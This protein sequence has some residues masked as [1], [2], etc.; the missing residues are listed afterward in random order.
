MEE[1]LKDSIPPHNLEAEMATLGALLIDWSSIGDI[2]T[3]LR[4]EHFYS[5]QNQIIYN[6]L[7][8]LFGTG[9]S[10]DVLTLET[11]LTK[12][13]EL[14]KAGG[15]AYI[16]SLTDEVPSAA[17]IDYYAHVV[18]DRATRRSLIKISSEIKTTA[19]DESR[20]SRAILDEAE[21][22]IFALADMGQTIQIHDMHEVVDKTTK[23]IQ[24]QYHNHDS[25]SGIP[26]GFT[27]LDSMTSGFQKSELSIIGARPSMGKTAMAL[28]MM[29]NI[30]VNNKIPC[31]F[32]SLEMSFEQIGQR[33]LSQVARI[34]GHKIRSGMMK[35]DDLQKINDAAGR[36]FDA[37]IYIVDTPNMQLLDLRAMAR[38]MVQSRQVQ[39][40]FIDYIGLISTQNP[41]AP[42]YEQVSEI[43]KSLKSLARELNIPVVALCQVARD[44]EG[45][46]PTL[47]QL[48]GSGSIEQD[49]D[50]VMFIHRERKKTEGGEMEPVQ[51][52]KLIVAKQRNGPIGDVNLLFLSSYTKFENKAN[53][54]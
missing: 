45:N 13:N 33:L 10:G 30:A 16:A 40:I 28:S 51:D 25:Y 1:R 2:V 26:C 31:G 11:E 54:D 46:E 20:E 50:V 5:Q 34:P 37:P 32:F 29:E 39:I 21:K 47:A 52:A 24:Q 17:N 18:L 38:R 53:E 6:A 9:I 36:V 35:L 41:S 15:P 22:K 44:A 12:S 4:P 3:F 49:A 14:E 19:F 23:I 48:R 7:I 27:R 8:K 42:V 43:S